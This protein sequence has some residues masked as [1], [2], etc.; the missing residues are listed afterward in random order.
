[1]KS[2]ESININYYNY[3]V[4]M[5]DYS[6]R[7]FLMRYL[8]PVFNRSKGDT[9]CCHSLGEGS[10]DH[11]QGRAGGPQYCMVEHHLCSRSA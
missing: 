1:M 5:P 10:S 9:A 8:W 4:I 7:F 3:R 11:A 2:L 6:G